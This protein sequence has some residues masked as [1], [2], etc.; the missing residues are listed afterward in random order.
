MSFRTDIPEEDL[1]PILQNLPMYRTESNTC[2]AAKDAQPKPSVTS[3]ITTAE[4]RKIKNLQ[5]KLQQ[6][7]KLKERQAKGEKLEANQV[8]LLLIM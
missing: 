2:T 5:L 6:I 4:E 1:I 3:V 7:E 8:H